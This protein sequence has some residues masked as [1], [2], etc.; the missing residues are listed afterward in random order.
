MYATRN[1]IVDV[2]RDSRRWVAAI[3]ALVAV[4]AA[5]LILIYLRI[6]V[7]TIGYPY[8]LE[9][10]E[11]GAVDVIGR[12]VDGAPIYTRPTAEYVPYL[13]PPLYYIAGAVAASAIGVDFAAA[14][15]VSFAAICC[16][17]VLIAGFV[18]REGGSRV[19]ALAAA[20]LFAGSF[21]HADRVFHLAR[22]DSLSVMLVLAAWYVWR[23]VPGRRGALVAGAV[24]WLAFMTKQTAATIVALACPILLLAEPRRTL[25]LALSFSILVAVTTLAMDRVTQGWWSYFIFRLPSLHEWL[26]R[27]SW[28][29][30]R[31]DVGPVVPIACAGA[32]VLVVA[33]R[34]DRRRAAAYLALTASAAGASLLSRMHS[35]GA[36]NV[37]LP[38]FAALSIVL[39]LAVHAVRTEYRS[40][41]AGAA[42]L[43][44]LA[45]QLA[46]LTRVPAGAVPTAADRAAG[47]RY[48][49][50]LAAVPGQVL[51]WHQ[52]FV[53]TRAGKRSWGLEMAAED[54]LRSSDSKTADALKSDVIAAFE[55]DRTLSAVDPPDWLRAAV[56]FGPPVTLFADSGVFR[57]IAGAPKRPMLYY[58]RIF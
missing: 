18:R 41:A 4:L 30:V 35:G 3:E 39:P 17:G 1:P 51:I 57:P 47:D 42:A 6:A 58:P 56:P 54:I 9:W 29:F 55:R 28:W 52:R 5:A 24:F 19:D 46:W 7:A 37:L 23:V 12:V 53:E 40:K 48:V 36:A 20:G 38:L 10:M 14:R 49:A 13:Y 11:G 21:D 43:I 22:V 27:M 2:M 16:A 33:W 34:H 44:A 32:A 25:M 8:P 45:A 15:A 31:Y 26:P 50:F